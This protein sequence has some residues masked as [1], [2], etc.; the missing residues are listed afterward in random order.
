MDFPQAFDAEGVATLF[1]DHRQ[2]TG[3]DRSQIHRWFTS[4][5]SARFCYPERDWPQHSRAHVAVLRAASAVEGRISRAADLVETLLARSAEFAELWEE[6]EVTARFAERKTLVHPAVGE[7]DL[8]CEA[9]LTQDQ[10]Q[11]LIV[12]TAAPRSEAADKLQLLAVL[13][14]QRFPGVD[15]EQQPDRQRLPGISPRG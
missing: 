15:G 7:M 8:D 11:T 1:G 4:P 10:N 3:R 6:H 9:L 12:L 14:S 13:G 2:W 5:D